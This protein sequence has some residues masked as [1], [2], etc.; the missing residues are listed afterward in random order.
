MNPR[1]RITVFA[2]LATLLGSL[3]LLPIYQTY[4]WIPRVVLIIATVAVISLLANRVRA[5]VVVAPVL[6]VAGVTMMVTLLYAHQVAPL[7]FLPG[8][9]ALRLLHQT[10]SDGFSDTT[11][12]A[13]PVAIT[14]GLS[15]MTTGGIG[16]VAVVVETL[17]TG[18]RRP[19][20][21]G[22]PLLAIFTVPAAILSDGVGWQPFVF[23]AAGYLALLLAEGRDR[24]TRWGR[25]VRAQRKPNAAASPFA[26][27]GRP[28]SATPGSSSAAFA[29]AGRAQGRPVIATNQLTQVGRRVGAAAIGVAIVVPVI[30]PGLHSGWFGTHHTNGAG[31]L[32]G[33]GSG[34]SIN[35]IVSMRRD[36]NQTTPVAL[37][38]YTTTGTPQYLRMLTLDKFDGTQW[39][40]AQTTSPNDLDAGKQI[41]TPAGVTLK[42]S[43]Q[44]TTEVTVDQLKEPYLP[45]PMVPTT[46]KAHGDW[47]YNPL[48]SVVYSKH[49]ST[50][51]LKYDVTNDVYDPAESVLNS[52]VNDPSNP[53]ISPYLTVPAHLPAAIQA[54][55]YNVVALA[56]ATTPYQKAV[57]LQTWFQ[58]N[59]IYDL[60]A[61]SGSDA[62]ALV[63]FLQDRT[64]YCEQFAATMALMA[65]MEGIPSRVDVGFTPGSKVPATNTY[66]VTTAD[67]HAWPELYFTGVGWLR[68]EPTPRS[69]GQ[70]TEPTYSTT[71]GTTTST[72]PSPT[73]KSTFR[74]GGAVASPGVGG[75]HI[76]VGP[77]TGSSG[78]SGGHLPIGWF[79]VL[80]LLLLAGLSAPAVRTIGRR[81]RWAAAGDP[82]G[83]AH[84]AWDELADDLRDLNLE[85]HGA[86][87]TP[88]RASAAL[89]AT[90]R[91][92]YDTGAQQAL[93]RLARA[94]ELAR[95]A[96]PRS[97]HLGDADPRADEL[98][99]RRALFDSVPRSR[100]LRARIAPP[101]T[102]RFFATIAND[103]ADNVR[104][105]LRRASDAALAK[106]PAR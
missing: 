89:L 25:P 71:T 50:V 61:K 86:T 14:R 65:R 17:A 23:G 56:H 37:F 82:A 75:G 39:T 91:L 85:W 64:G 62:S 27:P 93:V 95:Y 49:S 104:S 102:G 55:A 43:Q 98:R 58:S 36:L 100:R 66:L 96:S 52:I 12:L 26:P 44:V 67:A 83:R 24:I 45:V 13:A 31:G 28:R 63:S 72:G 87:D 18:L 4:G 8:P 92:N 101:S 103:F 88:R 77:A 51:R 60:S 32:G 1:T 3:S 10:L 80:F 94:E 33:D 57:A 69:D 40:P 99:V 42:P 34:T 81:R 29:T 97:A 46:V 105:S 53:A 15:L 73:A 48:T 6:M 70:T 22:L 47:L 35:P 2:S 9:A 90:R 19:A 30:I 76:P 106:L 38:T 54:Q 59:F 16:L 68:F 84:A 11:Q 41:P 7:G 74:P 20:V 5:L 79:V 21:A 78:S